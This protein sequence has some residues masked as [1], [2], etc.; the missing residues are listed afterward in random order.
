MT[1]YGTNPYERFFKILP[2]MFCTAGF[3]GRI[4]EVN[5][6]WET[7]LGF[8]AAEMTGKPCL[9]F[10]HPDERARFSAHREKIASGDSQ[11]LFETR[12]LC[13]DGTSRWLYMRWAADRER[14][15][16]YC[17]ATDITARKLTEDALS[18]SDTTLR[19]IIDR[20]PMSMSI[21]NMDGTIEYINRKAE[22]TFGYAH[23]DI[24]TMDHWWKLAY[25]DP[26]YRKEVV[27]RY[28]G[29]VYK[30]IRENTEVE[31]GE[32]VAT[33]KDGSKKTCYIFGVIAAG[34]VF[35]MFDDIT[36]RVEA[37]KALRQSET[38]LRRVIE[39]A[40]ISISI[41]S[42][43]GKLEF[44]NRKFTEI[45]GYL[46]EDIPTSERW[47]ELAYPDE[48]YRKKLRE[49][50]LELLIK[51]VQTNG[52]L[53]GSEYKVVAKDGSVKKVFIYGVVTAD[54]KVVS[55]LDDVTA[56]VKAEKEL[57]ESESLYRALIETTGTGYVVIDGQ[58]K[59]VDANREYVRLSGRSDLKEILGRSVLEWTAPHEKEKNAA[60]VAQCAKEGRISNFE[61]EYVDKSG[62][63]TPIEVNATVVTRGGV[64]RI[65][66]LCRDITQRRLSQQVIRRLNKGLEGGQNSQPPGRRE[67]GLGGPAQDLQ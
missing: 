23:T 58:G 18:E 27:E 54:K 50:Q 4:I 19:K 53:E 3:D 13:K 48:K 61:V 44:I 15:V 37:E 64:P 56:R 39:Q 5:E 9:D 1:D 7:Q 22:D 60:A 67:S 32:Y 34:K 40:P 55:L 16:L 35:V 30:A 45:F 43:E 41:H 65:L 63:A 28:M 62:K 31:G 49:Q 47:M 51:A 42:L 25:P 10:V 46:A 36:H 57:L 2:T 8:G 6:A 26:Q 20:A 21:V 33:C 29:H 52:E 14:N 59:V 38:T 24:P 17:A 12:F 66:T 11:A